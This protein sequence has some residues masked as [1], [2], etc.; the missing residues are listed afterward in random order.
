MK[1]SLA[2]SIALIG[3][4]VLIPAVSAKAQEC[5]RGALDAKYC[6]R[7][8]DLVA[9]APT[10]AGEWIDPSTLVFAYTP[11]E[12]P[13]VYRGV[14]DGFLRHMEKV[15]GKTSGRGLQNWCLLAPNGQI[16]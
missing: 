5:P 12:D 1:T 9:D 10:D 7:D 2:L 8:G 6:D 11:V 3:A 16:S 4:T 13:E 14:W 15:T